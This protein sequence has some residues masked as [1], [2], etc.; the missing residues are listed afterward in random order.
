MG[1]KQQT[2]FLYVIVIRSLTTLTVRGLSIPSL[3]KTKK[4]CRVSAA[5]FGKGKK[6]KKDEFIL[7]LNYIIVYSN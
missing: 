2:P 1:K 4:G 5:F 7:N 6:G 3:P